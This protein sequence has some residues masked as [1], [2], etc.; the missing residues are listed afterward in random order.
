[1][2]AIFCGYCSEKNSSDYSFC[3]K[4]GKPLEIS[5]DTRPENSEFTNESKESIKSKPTKHDEQKGTEEEL[6][7]QIRS[8]KSNY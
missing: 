2:E 4:C 3:I 1:M 6:T 8:D 7:N 5:K